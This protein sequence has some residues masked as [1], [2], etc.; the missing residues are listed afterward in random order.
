MRSDGVNHSVHPGLRFSGKKLTGKDRRD[1]RVVRMLR[2]GLSA[3]PIVKQGR[4]ADDTH[5]S[6]FVASNPLG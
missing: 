4:G 2:F 1:F 3:P 6:T 5:L